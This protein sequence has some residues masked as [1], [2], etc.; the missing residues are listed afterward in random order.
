M[1]FPFFDFLPDSGTLKD[2]CV[3][4]VYL[5][6]VMCREKTAQTYIYICGTKQRMKE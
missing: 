6:I 3:A 2:I 1:L 5:I 4:R